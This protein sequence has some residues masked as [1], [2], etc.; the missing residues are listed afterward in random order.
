LQFAPVTVKATA[1]F[2]LK[3]VNELLAELVAEI[4]TLKKG[5]L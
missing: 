2:V 5:K 4:E 3:P 1:E